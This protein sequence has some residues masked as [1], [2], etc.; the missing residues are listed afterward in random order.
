MKTKKKMNVSSEFK[1]ETTIPIV[2]VG[3]PFPNSQPIPPEKMDIETLTAFLTSNAD[4]IAVRSEFLKPYYLNLRSRLSQKEWDKLCKTKFN[5]TRRAIDYWLAGGNPAS[6]RKTHAP[7][8]AVPTP[9]GH[10]NMEARA[11]VQ[12]EVRRCL[13][14]EEVLGNLRAEIKFCNQADDTIP[15]GVLQEHEQNACYWIN[16]LYE[17]GC[18]VWKK[19]MVMMHE[20]VGIAD[21]TVWDEVRKLEADA[22][23]LA[24]KDLNPDLLVLF[25]AILILCRAK[26][27]R[28]ADNIALHFK[29]NPTWRPVTEADLKA[30]N[31]AAKVKREVPD[32]AI[33]KH[34][35]KGKSMG[36]GMEFFLEEGAKL[37]NPSA[38]V[39][40]VFSPD[41]AKGYAKGFAAGVASVSTP[42]AETEPPK[43]TKKPKEPKSPKSPAGQVHI[44][45]LPPEVREKVMSEIEAGHV[46]EQ[47]RLRAEYE[48]VPPPGMV[49]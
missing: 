26:K 31:A 48:E 34:T 27:C 46:V 10:N 9:D 38:D 2:P 12:K 28:A 14:D 43:P 33:D 36:R 23:R 17:A 40:E 32:Y 4:D 35:A 37:G 7:Q 29:Q 8:W 39:R 13:P 22:K 44:D 21:T 5:R 1:P 30:A 49:Q 25:N 6:K 3:K 24:T 11:A 45:E 15:D 16:Q 47:A 19:L 18:D 20:D 41:Y 42:L